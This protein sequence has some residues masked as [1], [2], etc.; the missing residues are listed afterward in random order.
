MKRTTVL[1]DTDLLIE[2]KQLA[3]RLDRTVAD[4][5]RAAL[6][7]FIA[8]H[9]HKR[10]FSFAGTGDSGDPDFAHNVDEYLREHTDPQLGWSN[11]GADKG[12]EE[13]Q[14]A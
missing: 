9:P 13:N 10:T 1:L 2:T 3:Q 12:R 14:R 7:E 8:A 6:T 11:R 4:V 5:I